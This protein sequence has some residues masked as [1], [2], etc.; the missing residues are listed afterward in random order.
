MLDNQKA[1]ELEAVARV[2]HVRGSRVIPEPGQWPDV[3]LDDGRECLPV[4]VARGY[5]R[6]P[7]EDP[8]KGAAVER[9]RARVD[10]HAMRLTAQDGRPRVF[11]AHASGGAAHSYIVDLTTGESIPPPMNPANP[12]EWIVS[13]VQ[14]KMAKSYDQADRTILVVDYRWMEPYE[15]ELHEI[16]R[17][18]VRL[19]C[20]FREVW[21]VPLLVS[22]RQ[23]VAMQ[24][25]LAR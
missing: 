20:P 3:W 18:L 12:V 5:E 7:G 11:G 4:E 16:G 25:P 21:V 17:H 14:Q 24:V 22:K 8:T 23:H 15:W 19:G 9:V 6:P 2:A 13:T 1:E 10:R